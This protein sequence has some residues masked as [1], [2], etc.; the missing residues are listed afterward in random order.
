[1]SCKEITIESPTKTQMATVRE[2]GAYLNLSRQSIYKLMNSGRL[3]YVQVTNRRR[4]RW[5]DVERLEQKNT[6]GGDQSG[7]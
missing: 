6:F 1:M 2:V 3:P 7:N 5:S 4:I